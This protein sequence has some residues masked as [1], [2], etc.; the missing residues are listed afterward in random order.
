MTDLRYCW[1]FEDPWN[2]NLYFLSVRWY[3]W[4]FFCRASCGDQLFACPF[5]PIKNLFYQSRIRY[6]F[7]RIRIRIRR[8]IPLTNRSRSWSGSCSFRQWPSTSRRQHKIFFSIFCWLLFEGTFTSFFKDR[9]H[10]VVTKEQKSRFF[11]LLCL[12]YVR[13]RIRIPW[14]TDPGGLKTYGSGSGTLFY[15]SSSAIGPYSVLF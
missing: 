12:G 1:F 14:L 9:I 13:I 11:F 10:K 15:D 6:I 3:Y 2:V 7:I 4:T 8:S 5:M